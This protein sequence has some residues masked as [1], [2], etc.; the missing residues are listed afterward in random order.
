MSRLKN[1]TGQ[2]FG[3]LV[4][5]HPSDVK[6]KGKM[7]QW[8]CQCDCG[9]TSTVLG[10][11]LTRGNTK[12]CGC[13]REEVLANATRTHG[14]SSIPE[15]SIWKGIRKRCYNE[16]EPAYPR[17]GGRGI[18]MCDEWKASFDAFLRDMGSRPSA[19]HSIDRIDNDLGYSPEN[20]RWADRTE[21]ARNRRLFSKNKTGIPGVTA[22]FGKFQAMIRHQKRLRFLGSFATLEEAAAA[23]RK[24]EEELWVQPSP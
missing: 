10:T 12:S 15:Y 7:Y 23:R 11:N 16:N 22:R 5:L 14:K 21:Q 13:H 3:R 4:A 9:N 17:Y 19:S 20:C 1:I 18:V 2:R 8:V 6:Y 24:A